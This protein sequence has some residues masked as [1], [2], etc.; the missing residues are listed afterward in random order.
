MPRH[1][2]RIGALVL[3]LAACSGATGGPT[4]KPKPGPD[5]GRILFGSSYDRSSFSMQ[6]QVTRA[7]AGRDIAFV[8]HFNKQV[9]SGSVHIQA[10]IDGKTSVD[11]A[12]PVT[13]GPWTVYGG[14]LPGKRLFQS[15]TLLM[16]FLDD[17][18]VQLCTGQLTL[19]PAILG[20]PPG[21][22]APGASPGPEAPASPGTLE[23]PGTPG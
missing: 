5:A 8:C 2:F 22:P 7:P 23:S 4:G 15:G 19:L 12:I 14:I 11:Q 10:V 3:L 6:G 21:S 20:S 17:T 13:Q 18:H 1:A 9:P 16:R